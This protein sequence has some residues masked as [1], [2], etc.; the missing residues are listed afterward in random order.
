MIRTH[1]RAMPGCRKTK[2]LARLLHWA[3][4]RDRSTLGICH[5]PAALIA[6]DNA[7]PFIYDSYEIAAFPDPVDKQTPIIG[8][9]PGHMPWKFGE[10]LGAF[11]V[12]I[13][14][15][16]ADASCHVDRRL[17]SRA[18]RKAANDFGGLA[19]EALLHAVR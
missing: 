16:K 19:A 12:T 18:S 17:I 6:S 1:L 13:V 2:N 14:N 15:T 5:F 4:A 7:K 3:Y 11:G 9:M 10:K 8:Y